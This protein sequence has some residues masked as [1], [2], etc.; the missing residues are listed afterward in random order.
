MPAYQTTQKVLFQHC[1]PARIVFYPRYFEMINA[2]IEEWFD[3]ALD[4]NFATM[5]REK[6]GVPTLKISCEFLKPSYLGD[7]LDVSLL[8]T[9][10]G[11]SSFTVAIDMHCKNE[12]RLHCDAVLVHVQNIDKIKP[13]PLSEKLVSVMKNF[14]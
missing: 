9:H 10:L 3:L 12:H 8:I 4:Y 13:E 11:K 6:A 7:L 5:H 1:D 2:T 14:M